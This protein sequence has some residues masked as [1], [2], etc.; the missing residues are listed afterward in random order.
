MF[1]HSKLEEHG[2][3]FPQDAKGNVPEPHDHWS[4]MQFEH[5]EHDPEEPGIDE[6]E[7]A[8]RTQYLDEQWWPQVIAQVEEE[9]DNLLSL[10]KHSP[11]RKWAEMTHKKP[12]Q[13]KA[14]GFAVDEIADTD[15]D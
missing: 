9:R 3:K 1:H 5:G 11:I 14:T 8:R 15:D 7:K 12:I 6:A 4:A 10:P 2:K 13:E